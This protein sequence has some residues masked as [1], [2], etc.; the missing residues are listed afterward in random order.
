MDNLGLT[1]INILKKWKRKE[2][3]SDELIFSQ[4]KEIYKSANLYVLETE[5]S[6]MKHFSKIEHQKIYNKT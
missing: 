1:S 5:F 4:N 3:I 6:I 2:Y